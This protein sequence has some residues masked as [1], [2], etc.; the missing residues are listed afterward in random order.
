VEMKDGSVQMGFLLGQTREDITLKLAT[1]QSL[2]VP[3][4]EVKALKSQ[5]LSL[6]PEGVLQSLTAE[7]LADLLAF[8]ESLK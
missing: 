4:S 5:P 7:E 6:M 2:K 3:M 8:L 1:G